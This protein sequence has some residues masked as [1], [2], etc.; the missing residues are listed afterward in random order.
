MGLI[1]EIKDDANFQEELTASATKLVVV[2]FTA[3]WCGPCQRIAPFYEQLSQKYPH[4]T[5]LKV[6]VDKCQD[7]A[8]IQN[9]SV[10][11][12]FYFF[13]NKVKIDSMQGAD[14]NKLEEKIKQYYDATAGG[15]EDVGVAGHSQK[16]QREANRKIISSTTYDDHPGRTCGRKDSVR[17]PT[18][19]N[20]NNDNSRI[21]KQNVNNSLQ[22]PQKDAFK[23]SEMY[24]KHETFSERNQT[25]R[26]P[27][28]SIPMVSTSP[29]R[30][31]I[32]TVSEIPASSLKSNIS[33]V[34]NVEE[35]RSQNSPTEAYTRCGKVKL[36]S[37]LP[38]GNKTIIVKTCS[39]TKLKEH[40]E[41]TVNYSISEQIKKQPFQNADKEKLWQI[42]D[43]GLNS[44]GSMGS[45]ACS[46]DTSTTTEKKK[47]KKCCLCF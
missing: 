44:A 8:A 9:V 32:T 46:N 11:P 42:E 20:M 37:T 21:N 1:R 30:P 7:T 6:D 17:F 10:M 12:T 41:L 43:K 38:P 2:D 4:A 31:K 45:S 19:D 24:M 16:R 14:R 13:R 35:T 29:P 47:K 3:T 26:S 27:V 23:K 5:F 18:R 25:Q 28:Q 36:P 15:E 34:P 39:R 33:R 40:N 22:S